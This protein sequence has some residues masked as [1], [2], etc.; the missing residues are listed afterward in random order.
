MGIRYAMQYLKTTNVHLVKDMGMI[1]YKLYKNYKF[2]AK[3]ISYKNGD[4]PY[5]NQEVK[6]LKLDFVNK[7]FKS[8][9][10]DGA[11]HL[12][13]YGKEIDILQVFHITLSTVAYMY[14]YKFKNKKGKIYLKLDCSYKLIERIA[15]LSN[16]Q[17][18]LLN[19]IL[20]K[21]DLISIEQEFLYYEL[22]KIL[23]KCKEKLIIL[24]NGV[25][26]NY[27]DHIDVKYNYEAKENIILTSAR[28]GAEEKN[29]PMLLEA[30][31]K[32]K[33]V[34]Y[35]NWKVVLAGPVEDS[36]YEYLDDYFIR[37]P[38]LK[39]KI[40]IKG[41]IIDRKKLYEEYMRAKIF[42]LTSD[43]ES[44]G[45]SFIEAAAYGDI[46]V[47]TDVGIVREIV[48]P[49][50]GALV[51]P[52]DIKAL[53]EELEKYMFKKDLSVESQSVYN[54]CKEK[55]NWDKI[56]KKLYSHLINL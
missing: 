10:L 26:Y 16:F 14:S 38:N 40:E 48:E 11:L 3:V 35:S 55:F 5:L 23:P 31:A 32:V 41:N 19:T 4:F 53:T 20:D 39:N 17:R 33:D 36:F 45:I 34:E 2:D 30:F 29:T 51:S 52:G 21:A 13:K 15:E 18:K 43:F 37:Y 54:L 50:Y 47:S 46:I 28:I 6:G 49:T 1:P 8:F 44:F 9:T 22:I 7:L 27:I 56:I 12:F 24:P 25:D 42:S